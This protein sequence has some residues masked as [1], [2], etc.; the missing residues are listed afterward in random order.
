[1]YKMTII[2]NVDATET[3]EFNS[4]RKFAIGERSVVLTLDNNIT[5]IINMD[6]I[7]H[8]ELD[9]SAAVH[10]SELLKS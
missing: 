6:A 5:K 7:H 4:L 1:M 8:I 2:Y 10:D 3:Y 9:S